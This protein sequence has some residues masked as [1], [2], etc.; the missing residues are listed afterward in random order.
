MQLASDAQSIIAMTDDEKKRVEELLA[1]LDSMPDI[2]EE[3]SVNQVNYR[4]SYNNSSIIPPLQRTL[5][6][7][8]SCSSACHGKCL[9]WHDCITC[10]IIF[11]PQCSETWHSLRECLSIGLSHSWVMLKWLKISKYA[12][13]HT[14]E[15]CLYLVKAKFHNRKFG[16][17]PRMSG[18]KTAK[19]WPMILDILET[20][21]NRM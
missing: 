10:I 9:N 19:I 5:V 12:L 11:G 20:V 15:R 16:G 7:L 21:Q 8:H 4:H 17:S 18:S 2:P 6:K 13:H 3:S 1:D 14:I